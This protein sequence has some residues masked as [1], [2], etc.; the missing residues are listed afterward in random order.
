MGVIS[1]RARK[2]GFFE[3]FVGRL[4][5]HARRMCFA[6]VCRGS[7]ARHERSFTTNCVLT[8]HARVRLF[9]ADSAADHIRSSSSAGRRP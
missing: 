8:T 5:K 6:F 4:R 3:T 7:R 2:I 9:P 1:E